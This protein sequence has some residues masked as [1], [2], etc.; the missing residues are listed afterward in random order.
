MTN[1][2]QLSEPFSLTVDVHQTVED[3][4]QL[5][6]DE[7][8]GF[9]PV[10]E[11]NQFLGFISAPEL[12]DLDAS[13]SLDNVQ[14]LLIKAFVKSSD[15]F[16]QA[17]KIRSKFQLNLIPVVSEKL[18]WEGVIKEDRLLDQAASVLGITEKGSLL[19]LEMSALD[20]AP[21][22]INRLVESNDAMVMGLNTQVDPQTGFMQ[23]ILR[24][25]REDISDVVA[26]F[27]R[28]DY[29]VLFYYGEEHYENSLQSNLDHLLNYL[30]I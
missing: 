29:T 13:V 23:V 9:V 8:D 5:F 3:V 17:L 10:L 26:S 6:G 2:S 25:N 19:V 24:I 15:H 14:H 12:E 30:N 18:E 22:E 11:G 20:Y 16:F 7:Y 21:G 1:C 4:F 27:Q 28:H